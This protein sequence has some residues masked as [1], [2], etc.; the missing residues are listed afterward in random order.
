MVSAFA[1]QEAKETVLGD[2]YLSGEHCVSAN[3]TTEVT[4]SIDGLPERF[5]ALSESE[6]PANNWPGFCSL[7]PT[8]SRLGPASSRR[9]KHTSCDTANRPHDLRDNVTAERRAY[10]YGSNERWRDR[11]AV[12]GHLQRV[13]GGLRLAAGWLR[14]S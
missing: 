6:N 13:G 10:R 1:T 14:P 12:H 9:S 8:S 4:R 7:R 2:S 5:K 11:R 3:L